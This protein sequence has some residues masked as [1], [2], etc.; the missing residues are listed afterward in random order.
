MSKLNPNP[1]IIQSYKILFTTLTE[2]TVFNTTTF[3]PVVL[4]NFTPRHLFSNDIFTFENETIVIVTSTIQSESISAVLCLR[5]NKSFG[6]S[7]NGRTLYKCVPDDKRIPPFLISYDIKRIGFSKVLYNQYVI[8]QFTEWIGSIPHGIILNNIGPVNIIENFYEY[9]L[10]CKSLN[11]SIQKFNKDTTISLQ[12]TTHEKFIQNI[13]DENTQIEDRSS[14]NIF[15]IDPKNTTEFDDGFSFTNAN[16]SGEY[17]ISIY[18][19]NV[20]ICI[21]KLQLWE[22]FSHRIST[23]YL[24]HK[25]RPM[26]PSVLSECLCS[27]I[28]SHKRI[29]FT[30]DILINSNNEVIHT[31]Y[32]N[33]LICVKH[34]FEY[35]SHSLLSHSNY[36]SLLDATQHL[37]KKYKYINNVRNSREMVCYLM[38]FMN[39]HCATKMCVF[40]NGIFRS[41]VIVKYD[42]TTNTNTNICDNTMPEDV[43]KFIK[44]WKSSSCQYVDK[45]NTEA[46]THELLEMDSYIHITSPIRRLVD[47]LNIIQFQQNEGIFQYSNLGNEFYKKWITD[48]DY[49]NNTMKTIRKVQNQ[50]ELLDLCNKNPEILTTQYD[51]YL[52]VKTKQPNKIGYQYTAYLPDIKLTHTINLDEDI[53]YGSKKRFSI[54]LF[55]DEDSLKRKIRIQIII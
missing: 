23:I 49:I 34:N 19:A 51:G 38:I 54:F 18:I 32:L 6:R 24:P 1:T 5:N 31:R 4:N 48:M 21:D 11:A 15:T 45:S 3:N 43:K 50:C 39:Y 40:N 2:F 52:F 33:S 47:L 13:V 30:L 8:I 14:W 7:K 16:E 55:S 9:Q 22:S 26:L 41:S 28:K 12:N 35:E 17:M 27:L 44:I 20:A 25:R 10:Y 37:S 36:L 42:T 46:I 29:A 53:P